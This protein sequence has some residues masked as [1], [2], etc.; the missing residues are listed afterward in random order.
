MAQREKRRPLQYILGRWPFLDLT[1]E[2]GEGVLIPRPDTELLCESAA[3]WL[4]GRPQ[5]RVLDLCAGSGCV[6]L[7]IARLCPGARVTAVELSQEALPYLRRNAARYPQ[8]ALTVKAGDALDPGAAEGLF[9]AVVSNPPYIPAEELEGLMPEV[10]REPRMALDGGDGL[11]FYR[12][13]A[14]IWVPRLQ[15]GGFCAVEVGVGQAAAVATLFRAARIG[16]DHR[17]PG[18]RRHRTGGGR[19]PPGMIF[20][21]LRGTGGD[22]SKKTLS[23]AGRW[24]AVRKIF[25][26]SK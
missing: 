3:D 1:L 10:R 11:R 2:V 13:I 5:P 4:K 16:R 19:L 18:S 15:P 25:S 6:G 22:T 7:G 9:D 21:L 8:Y 17:P 12:G 23:E 20:S 24:Q 26:D 14:R